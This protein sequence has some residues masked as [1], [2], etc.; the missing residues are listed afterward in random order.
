MN[1]REVVKTKKNWN[2]NPEKEKL[3]STNVKFSLSRFVVNGI[4]L[5]DRL[6]LH[7]RQNMLLYQENC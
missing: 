6:I 7:I 4:T 1:S 5:M 2:G 3:L